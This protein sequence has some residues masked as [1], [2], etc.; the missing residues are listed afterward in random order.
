M[1]VLLQGKKQSVILDTW[2][3][4]CEVAIADLLLCRQSLTP[5][6]VGPSSA[7]PVMTICLNFLLLFGV[8][9]HMSMQN[10]NASAWVHQYIRLCFGP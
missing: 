1:Q 7:S 2:L 5:F 6:S 8:Y 3:T 4:P 9:L 10:T